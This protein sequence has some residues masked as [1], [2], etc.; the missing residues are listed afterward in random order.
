M[1]LI[2][3]EPSRG[4]IA[5]PRVTPPVS[6]AVAAVAV[7]VAEAGVPGNAYS[8]AALGKWHLTPRRPAGSGPAVRAVAER[9]G[10]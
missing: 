2:L 9:V 7:L 6:A 5:H 3:V 4:D 8:T 10:F 1:Y